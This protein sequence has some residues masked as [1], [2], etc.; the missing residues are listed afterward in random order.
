M[1]PKE[2]DIEFPRGDTCPVKFTLQDKKGN[3]LT[4]KSS[5]ELIF[6]V[7][8]DYTTTIKK[9]QKKFSSGE[10]TQEDDGS[11]KLIIN[12]SDTQNWDYGRSVFDI[13]LISGDY[14]RTVAIG[15]LTLTNEVT[16]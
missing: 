8:K 12:P 3:I 15:S 5:D 13:C 10:I 1:D 7:K 6:T 11:Y 2:F 14:T 16:F 9:L 4:L